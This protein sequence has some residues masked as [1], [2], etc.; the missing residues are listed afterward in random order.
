MKH[1]HRFDREFLKSVGVYRKCANDE[2]C[3]HH[4]N[5]QMKRLRF[6]LTKRVVYTLY[7]TDRQL[8]EF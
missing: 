4:S 5:D 6:A 2:V 3:K 7:H 8:K 1:Q